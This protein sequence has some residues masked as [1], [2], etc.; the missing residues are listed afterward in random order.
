[1]YR[2]Q[3]YMFKPQNEEKPQVQV[4]PETVMRSLHIRYGDVLLVVSVNL[5]K[6]KKKISRK[7][8]SSLAF[9]ELLSGPKA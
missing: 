1:M 6:I 8:L 3:K 7:K 9:L 4:S 2:K 5:R